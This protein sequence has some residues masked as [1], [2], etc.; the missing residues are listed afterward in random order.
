MFSL[1]EETKEVTLFGSKPNILLI[2]S[3]DHG[4][5]DLSFQG[6]N[7]DVHTP[8]LDRLR[9]SGMSFEQG[10]VSAP[11][12]SPSRAGL[13]VESYQQRWGA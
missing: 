8:N 6:R 13:M 9:N 11:I 12:C 1:S 5:G 4:Y 7:E 3:D 2:L 10:F